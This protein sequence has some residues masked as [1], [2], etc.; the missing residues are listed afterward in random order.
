LLWKEAVIAIIAT[1]AR[2]ER[3]RMG[4]RIRAGLARARAEGKR[5]GRPAK[6][7]DA[8]RIAAL[9][10]QGPGLQAHRPPARAIGQNR[11]PRGPGRPAAGCKNM[12]RR[13]C[14]MSWPVTTSSKTVH[15]GHYHLIL[16]P[17]TNT[18]C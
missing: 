5:L 9:R 17:R 6:T 7:V 8:A 12:I 4:E 18:S 2:Q 15:G 13:R 1:V 3:I 16:P 14:A 10:A 11:A